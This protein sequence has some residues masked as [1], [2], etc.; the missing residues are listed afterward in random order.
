MEHKSN[1][2][3]TIVSRSSHILLKI[4]FRF[5]DSIFVDYSCIPRISSNHHHITISIVKSKKRFEWDSSCGL[6]IETVPKQTIDWII[7]A[8]TFDKK[9]HK[10]LEASKWYSWSV[11]PDPKFWRRSKG[12]TRD[13]SQ[14]KLEDTV[15]LTFRHFHCIVVCD[16]CSPSSR[17]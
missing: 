9:L 14:E 3:Q 12:K 7:D 10:P 2:Q 16:P 8:N 6:H 11:C 15:I 13:I 5:I 1:S 17:Y 4:W